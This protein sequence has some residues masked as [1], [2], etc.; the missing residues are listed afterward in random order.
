LAAA[1]DE[2]AELSLELLLED[3]ATLELLW[4]DLLFELDDELLVLLFEQATKTVL[5]K[6]NVVNV[7][8]FFI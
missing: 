5:A 2:L 1:L 8:N 7:K 6:S 4:L 3:E